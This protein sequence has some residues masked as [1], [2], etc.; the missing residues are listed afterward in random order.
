MF[1]GRNPH[2]ALYANRR[3]GWQNEKWWELDKWA[4]EKGVKTY[5]LTD[6]EEIESIIKNKFD[7]KIKLL[8]VYGGD[9]TLFWVIN[10]FL[11]YQDAKNLPTI[12]P[13]GGGTM[14]R[15]HGWAMWGDEPAQNAKTALT[16]F[17]NRC[18]PRLLIQLL[19]IEWQNHSYCG[20][21]FMVGAPVRIL[22]KYSEFKSSPFV[23]VL[24]CCGGIA[25]GLAKW[26]SFF[27]SYYN[28][29]QADVFADNQ[30]LP[31]DKFIV[32][33]KD[34]L[35]RLIFI[36]QPYKGVCQPEQSFS[37]AYAIDYSELAHKVW[38]LA[39]GYVPKDDRYFNRPTTVLTVKPKEKTIFTI[40]GEFFES[41]PGDEIKI[42][43]GPTI[44][45]ATNPVLQLP[46]VNRLGIKMDKI[47]KWWNYFVPVLREKK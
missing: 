17:D 35:R 37:L 23:A 5:A 36:I 11:K 26:P 25:A 30:K 8:F 15:L 29:A 32:I 33:A 3:A 12:V 13:V 42:S 20:V 39:F 45:V 47:K 4:L 21:T 44:A 46:F 27:T 41:A 16:L 6:F 7:E 2:L 14:N 40:D 38:K 34:A 1:K 24:F 43:P 28:Q 22:K 18:L 10:S 9:G 19:S 31:Y